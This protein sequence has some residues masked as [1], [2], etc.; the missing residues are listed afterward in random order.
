MV[1][2]ENY[3]DVMKRLPK[4]IRQKRPDLWKNN[5]WILHDDNTPS[6]KATAVTE[7]K[8]KNATNII[9]QPP[10]LPDLSSC[11]PFLFPKIKL[12]LQGTR[13]DSIEVINK[14]RERS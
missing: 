14:I 1:K 8:V 13:F 7:F 12:P 10:Y 5:L 9:N 3:L 2:T 4:K 11:D 6:V